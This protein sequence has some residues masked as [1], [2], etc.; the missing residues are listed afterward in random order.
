M[1]IERDAFS[2]GA[3]SDWTFLYPHRI[4]LIWPAIGFVLLLAWLEFRGRGA[5][6]RFMSEHMGKRLT[7]SLSRGQRIF[8]LILISAS[9][10]FAIVAL[11]RPQ[12]LRPSESSWAK[13]AAAEIMVALDVS[14]SMLAQDAAPNRLQ[15]AKAEL[16]DLARELI[17][18]RMGLIAFAGR[19]VILS[20][21]TADRSFFRLVLSD[22]NSSTVSRG[23]T[24]IGD[25]IF[26]A[27]K[28]FSPNQGAKVIVLITDGEDH[29]SFP[30]DAA[31]EARD[32]GVRIIAIGFGS[33]TGAPITITDKTTGAPTQLKDRHGKTV[34]SRLDGETLR[35]V[36]L[37]T[38]GVY[39]PAGVGVLDLDSIIKSHIDPLIREA[40]MVT[41]QAITSEKYP[42]W[43]ILSFLLFTLSVWMGSFGAKS[44]DDI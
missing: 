23:G 5:L 29:D 42:L 21:M 35:K 27:L 37:E 33:E 9:I 10:L 25:A 17:D 13:E 41:K 34:M 20:P 26:K 14:R 1:D 32:L 15:R 22:V 18:H 16:R 19:S 4:H 36:A 30:L 44:E 28:G 43:I 3:V 39:V 8:R 12:S 31:K 6:K 38:E 2:E 7:R 24:R 40:G 11:M